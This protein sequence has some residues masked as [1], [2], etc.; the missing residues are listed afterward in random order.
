MSNK[1]FIDN[2]LPEPLSKK[3]LYEC[4]KKYKLGDN[5]EKEKIILHNIRLVLKETSKFNFS[6]YDRNEMVSV[7]L[8]GL[9][10][11][12]DSFDITKN[13]SFN[14]YA[15]PCIRNEILMFLRKNSKRKM[16]ISIESSFI[17]K[18]GENQGLCIED[19]LNTDEDY[20]I[21]IDCENN[22]INNIVRNIIKELP[23]REKEIVI[24]Y[25]GFLNN[26]IYNQKE[27]AK[28]LNISQSYVSKI[29][30]NTLNRVRAM[31]LLNPFFQEFD[32][33]KGVDPLTNEKVFKKVEDKKINI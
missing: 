10:K 1:L 2:E 3:E 27:I 11:A 8:I 30:T 28:K 4:F 15:I 9:I 13:F 20:N 18:T 21:A 31:L 14:T 32:F 25:F 33:E 12:V 5:K 23:Y 19:I 26:K 24:L 17:N 16:E 6:Y 22:E 29:L 7:G